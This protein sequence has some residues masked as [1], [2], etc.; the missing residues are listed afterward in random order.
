MSDPVFDKGTLGRAW[1]ARELQRAGDPAR[2]G[3]LAETFEDM[4]RRGEIAAARRAQK[5]IA[6]AGGLAVAALVAL[7]LWVAS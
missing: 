7:G 6:V 1:I 5:R 3:R 4:H 2:L